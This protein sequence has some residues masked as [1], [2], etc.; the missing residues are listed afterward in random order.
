MSHSPAL[1][2]SA[3]GANLSTDLGE[4]IAA[5][6]MLHEV[7]CAWYARARSLSESEMSVN[8]QDSNVCTER[9]KEMLKER[10][11]FNDASRLLSF[12][13]D[14]LDAD[15]KRIDLT[16]LQYRRADTFTKRFRKTPPGAA[17]TCDR[18]KVVR[19][20]LRHDMLALMNRVPVGFPLTAT[21]FVR[22]EPE[23]RLACIINALVLP[24][25]TYATAEVNIINI[26]RINPNY[27]KK[28]PSGPYIANAQTEVG[29]IPP[30]IMNVLGPGSGKTAI[31]ILSQ[32]MTWAFGTFSDA[33]LREIA[34]THSAIRR[35]API[36]P[37]VDGSV[38]KIMI[39]FVKKWLR[40]HWIREAQGCAEA[41][42]D[43][44]G[45]DVTVWAHAPG[46]SASVAIAAQDT[47]KCYIWILEASE[48]NVI[49]ALY[50][51]P[52]KAIWRYVLDEGI[53]KSVKRTACSPAITMEVVVATPDTINE[54]D[55][56]E[57]HPVNALIGGDKLCPAAQ[58]NQYITAGDEKS[59]IAALTQWCVFSLFAPPPFL[60]FLVARAIANHMP[61]DLILHRVACPRN[62]LYERS[63]IGR[64]QAGLVTIGL[65]QLLHKLSGGDSANSLDPSSRAVISR[66]TNNVASFSLE[67]LDDVLEKVVAGI[68]QRGYPSENAKRTAVQHVRRLK[69][70]LGALM[71]PDENDSN[72]CGICYEPMRATGSGVGVVL[73]C[74]TAMYHAECLSPCRNGPSCRTRMHT[75][76]GARMDIVHEG[77]R[78]QHELATMTIDDRLRAISAKNMP[79]PQAA[80]AAILAL[81]AKNPDA[82][83]IVAFSFEGRN[84]NYDARQRYDRVLKGIRDDVPSAIVINAQDLAS[85]GRDGNR[86]AQQILYDFSKIVPGDTTPQILVINSGASS[87]TAAGVAAD[88]DA[89]L[90]CDEPSDAIASQLLGRILRAGQGTN[91]GDNQARVVMLQHTRTD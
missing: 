3:S 44:Y 81:V 8:E 56:H 82:R 30:V 24:S 63:G 70:R 85:S 28:L 36:A 27:K 55:V 46:I 32:L 6:R 67:A 13:N 16:E 50:S 69:E 49:G 52:T 5:R 33:R 34:S 88:A 87:E 10:P 39:V 74:C 90:I 51:S 79:K 14:G 18:A 15:R 35:R 31:T 9:I 25:C 66:F 61:P 78:F 77:D 54:G 60:M 76:Q 19:E 45:L 48:Q 84:H 20:Y 72:T 22:L 57:S 4:E 12:D 17:A 58:I 71:S 47:S 38:A 91:R 40:D 37:V 43:L 86:T 29:C 23:Q 75:V 7:P 64:E 41:A 53:W 21:H 73:T 11:Q 80:V 83:I 2:D 1:S 26:A 89:M 42:R 59:L 62:S 68:N 65:E